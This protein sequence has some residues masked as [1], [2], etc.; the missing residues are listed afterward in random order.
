MSRIKQQ[1]D[2][3]GKVAIVT[4]ASKGI[5]ESIA[6]GLA[7]MGATVVV[8]SRKQEAVNAVAQKLVDAGHKATGK[9]CHMGD[10]EQV[11]ALLEYTKATHGGV[12]I[13]V[14]N[15]ATNPTFGPLEET[16]SDV[17]D[18]I[19]QVNVKGPLELCKQALPS[20]V[21]RGGGS[22][23]NISSVEGMKPTFGLGLYSTSKAALIML[24]QNMAKEWGN[25]GVRANVVCPGL[26][27]TKFSAALWKNEKIL[28]TYQ[29]HLPLGRMAQPDEMAG[30][31]VFL[32][33][34][35]SSYLT[36]AVVTADGG[37]ML[38]G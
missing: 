24:T 4:G 28:D 22:I 29:K 26:V 7:E 5:G 32:A 9:A 18:K 1:F 8:S 36:G 27:Q 2:L 11:A 20:M 23:V 21:E 25:R 35:A 3:N 33:S 38:A 6:W 13:V 34:P 12:D 37:Y 31:A 30:L 16:D 15:A 10:L 14:N 17:F 19:M